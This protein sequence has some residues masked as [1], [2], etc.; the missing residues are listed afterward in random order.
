MT[1]RKIRFA[2]NDVND[3]GRVRLWL[4]GRIDRLE[5]HPGRGATVRKLRVLDYKNSRN[6]KRYRE[7]V[8]A[9]GAQ[10]GWTDFQLP[11]YLMG[12]LSEFGERLAA[13]ATLEAGYLVLRNREKEQVAPVERALVDL[14]PERRAAAIKANEYPIAE[15]IVALVDEALAGRFDVDPRRCDDWCPYRTVCRYYKTAEPGA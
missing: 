11:V 14:S 9:E 15:R 1:E 3:S 6:A 12:A 8:D 7:M 2:L 13:D 5:L 10:F 4:E